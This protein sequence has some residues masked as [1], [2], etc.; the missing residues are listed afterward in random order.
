VNPPRCAA[1]AARGEGL[2]VLVAV[3]LEVVVLEVVAGGG[4]RSEGD[5]RFARGDVLLCPV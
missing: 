1:P 3:V 5:V 2:V 4:D